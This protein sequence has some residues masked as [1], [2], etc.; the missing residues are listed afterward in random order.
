MCVCLLFVSKRIVVS[1]KL[2]ELPSFSS[3]KLKKIL[4]LNNVGWGSVVKEIIP[5]GHQINKAIHLFDKIEDEKI[6]EQL[7][8][9]K[10]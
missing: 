8:K 10:Q 9:L 6:Q 2:E 1:Q 4:A 3:K 5:C 7:E